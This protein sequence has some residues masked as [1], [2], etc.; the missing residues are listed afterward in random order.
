MVDRL[1]ED[2]TNAQR[3]AQGLTNIKGISLE[4]NNVPT[5]IVVFSLSPEL[6]VNGFTRGIEKVGVKI[7]LRGR[8][9]FRAVTHHMV[10]SEDIDE[11]IRRIETIC[12]EL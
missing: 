3:L 11:A 12:H 1:R 8:N 10:S 2:H 4:R 6:S 5:N 7:G 9:L